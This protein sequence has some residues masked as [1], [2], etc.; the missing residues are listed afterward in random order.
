M[1]QKNIAKKPKGRLI[2][3]EDVEGVCRLVARGM[4]QTHAAAR[5]G[6][7]PPSFANW[8]SENR[9]KYDDLLTRLKASRVDG[10]L[11]NV[12]RAANGEDGVRLDWR[13]SEFLLKL[14]DPMFRE[15]KDNA[16]PAPVVNVAILDSLSRLVYSVDSPPAQPIALPAGDPG[17]QA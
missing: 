10:L 4:S 14:A 9:F 3:P 1:K 11:S 13:A 12:E 15:S 8:V 7:N 5:I 16:P 6:L 17:G 2:T